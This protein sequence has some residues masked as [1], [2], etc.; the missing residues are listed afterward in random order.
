[1]SARDDAALVGSF[2]RRVTVR[3][4]AAAVLRGAAAGLAMALVALLVMWLYRGWADTS[5]RIT[6]AL[7]AA[8]SAM[9]GA[10]LAL[11]HVRRDDAALLAERRTAES[12]NLIITAAELLAGRTSAGPGVRDAVV[13]DAAAVIRRTA[14]RDVQPTRRPVLGAVIGAGACALV[15]S[16]SAARPAALPE[17]VASTSEPARILGIDVVVEPPSWIGGEPQRLSDPTRIEALEGSVLRITVRAAASSVTME[18]VA[19]AVPLEASEPRTFVAGFRVVGDDFLSFEPRDAAGVAGARRLT[20]LTA[21]HDQPP[22]VRI[23]APG[24]D[25][26]LPH[27]DSVLRLEIEAEDDHALAS[28]S[29]RY[30]KVTG[31]GEQFTFTDGEV[32]LQV[33][34]SSAGRWV[35]RA[36]WPLT[37]LDLER[38]N[39]VVYRAVATDRRPGAAPG[40]SDTY[41]VEIGDANVA[42]AGGFAT[43]E[44]PDRYALS[45]Q[46]IVVLTER[47]MARRGELSAAEFAREVD[48]LAA[49][50][51][52]V[53]AEFVF[54]LGGEL[55]DEHDH[56]E[57]DMMELHEEAHAQADLLVLEGRMGNQGRTEL[58]RA[59]QSMSHAVT[60]L[61]ELDMDEALRAEQT[62]VIFL[63]RAF[64]RSRY[65]L[66]A[67]TQQERLDLDRRLT[68][69]LELARSHARQRREEATDSTVMALRSVLADAATLAA[70]PQPAAAAVADMGMRLMAVDRT[71]GSLHEIAAAF[72][73]ASA[74]LSDGRD[75][76]GRQRLGEG[77]AALGAHVR[78]QLRPAPAPP[79]AALR[80]L[81]GAL[82]DALADPGPGRVP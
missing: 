52:R 58:I 68:G 15:L 63:Q 32:P 57:H 49:A 75:A 73:E 19:G 70:T 44:D 23:T 59:I 33:T 77:V 1:M 80:R 18:S 20:G 10:G 81:D 40:E 69:S 31:F 16:V 35:A 42:A 62:A 71:D 2:L 78:G 4:R 6:G 51:R 53:R 5:F 72:A 9:V 8:A 21:R 28:L 36:Q 54:M 41:V 67:L 17:L 26:I 66:R 11:L 76:H 50:Q 39:M 13:A 27:A 56:E 60:F 29:L 12:R 64:A 34:R 30:T 82:T 14:P 43:D 48:V 79:P 47:L 37:P 7:L 61:G 3:V 25:L 46:M 22:A 74:A 45:Q 65:I 24:R 38:G 55:G